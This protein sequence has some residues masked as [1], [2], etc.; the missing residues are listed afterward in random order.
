MQF[1]TPSSPYPPNPFSPYGY[2]P[3]PPPP[4]FPSSRGHAFYEYSTGPGSIPTPAPSPR[5]PHHSRRRSHDY[6]TD[7]V[8]GLRRAATHGTHGYGE[9][10]PHDYATPP[11]R[12]HTRAGAAYLQTPLHTPPPTSHG[13]HEAAPPFSYMPGFQQSDYVSPFLL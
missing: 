10:S 12:P 2:Y 13:T 7:F 6:T 11:P 4:N 9:F 8:P 3:T 5:A 1:E